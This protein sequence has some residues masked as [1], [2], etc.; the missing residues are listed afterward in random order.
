[1]NKLVFNSL[2]NRR[3]IWCIIF[4]IFSFLDRTDDG[5]YVEL[6]ITPSAVEVKSN[7][8][9]VSEGTLTMYWNDIDEIPLLQYYI[10]AD[11]IMVFNINNGALRVMYDSQ[12]LV[13]FTDDHRSSTRGICGQSTSQV[14]DDYM[15][16]WGLV[17]R[18]EYYGASFSLDGEF[19]DPK[20][21]ELKKEAKLK[22]YQPVTKSTNILHCDSE[23]NKLENRFSKEIR[24]IFLM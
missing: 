15:T 2:F 20:T 1:M 4:K 7:T 22:A 9:K 6:E 13:I 24:S 8:K 12:R 17:D 23:W 5:K 11:G 10:L 3:N 18:P 19:S 16:P 21:V 14:R